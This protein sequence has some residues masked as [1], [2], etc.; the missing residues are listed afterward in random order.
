M[1]RSAL[2]F[3][4]GLVDRLENGIAADVD[5]AIADGLGP[6]GPDRLLFQQV[7]VEFGEAV[8][9]DRRS[10]LDCARL[11]PGRCRPLQVPCAR[12]ARHRVGIRG[13]ARSSR[14]SALSCQKSSKCVAPEIEGLGSVRAV[15]ATHAGG[16]NERRRIG[17]SHRASAP[18]TSNAAASGHQG[19]TGNSTSAVVNPV[20][21]DDERGNPA[22]AASAMKE[23][24]PELDSIVAG[25]RTGSIAA[26]LGA[27][28]RIAASDGVAIAASVGAGS[29][30]AASTPQSRRG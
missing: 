1:R 10:A 7:G 14:R 20:W 11:R 9:L 12:P 21:L 25:W 23:P 15:G 17:T 3:A 26:I 13:R 16:S 4:F 2:G 29:R 8:I 5:C 28:S 18:T 19:A 30:I 27:A 24:P 22:A 6:L